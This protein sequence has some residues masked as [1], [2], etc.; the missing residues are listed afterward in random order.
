MRL[1][2]WEKHTHSKLSVWLTVLLQPRWKSLILSLQHFSFKQKDI[3]GSVK[4]AKT[5]ETKQNQTTKEY[6]QKAPKSSPS[7]EVSV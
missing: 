3:V 7:A 4:K 2:N 1:A 5:K 6:S